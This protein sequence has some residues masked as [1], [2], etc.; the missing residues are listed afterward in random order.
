M[1]NLL[2]VERG[3]WHIHFFN[4]SSVSFNLLSMQY[5]HSNDR[6][7]WKESKNLSKSKSISL[8]NT[9]SNK[10]VIVNRKFSNENCLLYWILSLF[11]SHLLPIDWLWM[12]ASENTFI[13]IFFLYLAEYFCI[14]IFHHSKNEIRIRDKNIPVL[15][16]TTIQIWA[17]QAEIHWIYHRQQVAKF[18]HFISLWTLID[19]CHF[20]ES[21]FYDFSIHLQQTKEQFTKKYTKN[22]FSGLIWEKINWSKSMQNFKSNSHSNQE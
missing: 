17:I 11:H 6:I 8:F 14:F 13:C 10:N 22:T 18:C 15:L 5:L 3:F 4:S 1:R 7:R 9:E 20:M 19:V 16:Q 2:D 12:T 21:F